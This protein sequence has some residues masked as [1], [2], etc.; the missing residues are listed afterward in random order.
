MELG[1]ISE[2]TFN[3][4][5]LAKIPLYVEDEDNGGYYLTEI[6]TAGKIY[7]IDQEMS[8]LATLRDDIYQKIHDIDTYELFWDES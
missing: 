5:K 6:Y 1:Q 4:Y 8:F 2:E 3:A 7:Y